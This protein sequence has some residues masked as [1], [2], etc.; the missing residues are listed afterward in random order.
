MT[1]GTDRGEAQW[2]AQ[3]RQGEEQA[4]AWLVEA[5][6]VPV[7]NVCYRLLGDRGEAED[8]AQESFLRAY[9]SMGSYDPERKFRTWLLSI[10]SHYCIDQLRRRRI[11]AY[12]FEEDDSWEQVGEPAPGPEAA[13]AAREKE[14]ALRDLLRHLG[15]QDRAAIVLRY[16]YDLSNEEIARSL[17]L[18][19]EAVKS[20]LHRARREL[21]KRWDEGEGVRVLVGGGSHGTA[22]AV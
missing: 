13:L 6:Q 3:A 14:S 5:Y 17:S 10:A 2:L 7:Y 15:P 16:W 4:F 12:S 1:D 9:R 8:A 21:A 22:S 19:V 11:N 18:S 20:R